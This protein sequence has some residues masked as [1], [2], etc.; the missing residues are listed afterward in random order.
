MAIFINT[1]HTGCLYALY[2]A[3]S[4]F[5]MNQCFPRLPP[6]AG[7][8]ESESCAVAFEHTSSS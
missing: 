7:G 8:G 6:A 5:W 3:C 2:L 1:S 4:L